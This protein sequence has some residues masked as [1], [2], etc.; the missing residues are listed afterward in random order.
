MHNT[1]FRTVCNYCH[2]RNIFMYRLVHSCSI[3]KTHFTRTAPV[4]F[5]YL[6]N[7]PHF[8]RTAP[9]RFQYLPNK[10]KPFFLY[11]HNM[12]LFRSVQHVKTLYHK[13]F[14][15]NAKS[16]AS[17]APISYLRISYMFFI[18]DCGK[19]EIYASLVKRPRA[20]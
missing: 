7:K 11:S 20:K 14:L 5:Q 12:Q 15:N 1:E 9:V 13:T 6:P 10:T 16:G 4:R 2:I 18:T 3:F 19:F 8:T 17:V